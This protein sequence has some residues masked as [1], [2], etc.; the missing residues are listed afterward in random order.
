MEEHKTKKEGTIIFIINYLDKSEN[1]VYTLEEF[2]S[3]TKKKLINDIS[4]LGIINTNL[5]TN[6]H[7]FKLYYQNKPLLNQNTIHSTHINKYNTNK[8]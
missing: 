2:K 6:Y 8:K 5:S 7:Q 3:V 1:L 4:K